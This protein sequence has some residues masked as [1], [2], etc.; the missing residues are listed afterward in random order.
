MEEGSACLCM[1]P[2]DMFFCCASFSRHQLSWSACR[3]PDCGSGMFRPT[4]QHLSRSSLDFPSIPEVAHLQPLTE[5]RITDSPY[6]SCKMCCGR[7]VNFAS[8][9]QRMREFLGSGGAEMFSGCFKFPVVPS[10]RILR[11]ACCMPISSRNTR[12]IVPEDSVC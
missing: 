11:P 12:P 9:P 2:R 10:Q 4:E 8:D 7:A 1:T 6:F 5:I 3:L